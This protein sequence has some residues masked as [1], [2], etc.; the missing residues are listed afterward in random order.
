M[1][2]DVLSLHAM[3]GDPVSEEYLK[4][5]LYHR[6]EALKDIPDT[7]L[8][9]GRLDYAEQS[10]DDGIAG[11]SFHIGRRHVHAPDGTPA[12]IDWRAPVSRPFYRASADRPDEPGAAAALRVLRRRADRLR[13]RAVRR[14]RGQHPGPFGPRRGHP[15]EPDPDRRDR[16][17]AV[18]THARHRRD[19]PAR[20]GRY[21]ARRRWRRPSA[22][23][24]R[25]APGRPR[26]G[27]TGSR[28]CCTRTAS[29]PAARRGHGRAE[30]GLPLLHPQR[31]AGA[32]RGRRQPDHRRRAGRLGPGPWLGRRG[33]RDRQGRRADGGGAA[34][35]RCGP[36]SARRRPRWCCRTARGAGGWPPGRSRS[37]CTSCGT[38]ASATAR[39]AS[40]SGT[41]SRT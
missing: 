22:C 38:A 25:P 6:A 23:R 32:R 31:P 4:A 24:A 3:G 33:G 13:G 36:R 9:F 21:R 40:C 34:H 11:H 41:G 1:R 27:C 16:A 12:V 30:P 2:E 37:S 14:D 5:E 15:A 29:G 26:S 10:A 7:P 28:T 19:H 17:A 8:F 18:G 20:P 35:G 39:P